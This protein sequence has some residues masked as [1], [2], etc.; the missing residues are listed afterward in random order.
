MKRGMIFVWVGAFFI[1]ILILFL[2]YFFVGK[3]ETGHFEEGLVVL[4]EVPNEVDEYGCSEGYF[5]SEVKEE[6][7]VISGNN[8]VRGSVIKINLNSV[9]LNYD[10]RI[11]T[12]D[13]LN[14]SHVRGIDVGDF[15]EIEHDGSDFGER[16]VV[17][18]RFISGNLFC[19]GVEL[20]ECPLGYECALN[21][22]YPESNGECRK[23]E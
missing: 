20:E 8:V 11:E 17:S 9:V 21:D 5:W 22:D 7:V 23:S 3:F 16:S 18:I 1:A 13:V 4:G 15:I 12:F 19:G 14:I 2:I 6:C 10:F